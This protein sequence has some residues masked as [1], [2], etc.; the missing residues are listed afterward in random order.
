MDLDKLEKLGELK[1]KGIITQEEFDAKKKEFMDAAPVVGSDVKSIKDP[2]TV[3][4][5]YKNCFVKYFQLKGRANRKEYW[6]FVLM[7]VLIA[8]VLLLFGAVGAILFT[9]Y[10]I[11]VIIPGFT[12]FVRRC[13]DTNHSGWNAMLPFATTFLASFI[14]GLFSGFERTA[15]VLDESYYTFSL[16]VTSICGLA[17]IAVSVYIFYLTVKKGDAKENKYGPIPE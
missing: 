17:V 9:I 11:A 10:N 6:S 2:V 1:E 7:N 4:D 3:L 5:A 12:V 8:I 15:G 14:S 16:T 13:H